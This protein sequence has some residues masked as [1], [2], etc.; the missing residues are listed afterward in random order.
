VAW[1]PPPDEPAPTAVPEGC[2]EL[3]VEPDELPVDEVDE[4]ED[5]VLA[6][7]VP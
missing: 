6:W 5:A 7:A 1:D 3:D 4:V 2:Q